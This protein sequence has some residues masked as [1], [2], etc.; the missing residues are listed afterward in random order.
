MQNTDIDN[1]KTKQKIITGKK[2]AFDTPK[3]EKVKCKWTNG[4]VSQNYACR[5]V[6]LT[7]KLS[8]DFTYEKRGF[9]NAEN[10]KL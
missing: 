3:T 5:K 8:R 10:R 6:I 1:K 7:K 2:E 4:C 9:Q